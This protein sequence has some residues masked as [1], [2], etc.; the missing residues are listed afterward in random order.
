MP[1]TLLRLGTRGG[2]RALGMVFDSCVMTASGSP[3]PVVLVDVANAENI[4]IRGGLLDS[5][6]AAEVVAVRVGKDSRRIVLDNVRIGGNV[7]AGGF[8]AIDD[9]SGRLV[10]R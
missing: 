8:R 6:S 7:G 3:A 4:S 2:G 5:N 9:E 1:G 10:V